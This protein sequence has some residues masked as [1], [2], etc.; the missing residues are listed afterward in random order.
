LVSVEVSGKP[1]NDLRA[2][3]SRV[4]GQQAP[5]NGDNELRIFE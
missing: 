2:Q 1:S 3:F 4:V 5:G